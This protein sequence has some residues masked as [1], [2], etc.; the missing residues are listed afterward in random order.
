MALTVTLELFCQEKNKS[1]WIL[2]Q[3]EPKQQKWVIILTQC[4]Y[5]F[6]GLNQFS[7]LVGNRPAFI[8]FNF[9]WYRKDNT[10][11]RKDNTKRDAGCNPVKNLINNG[12]YIH[13][14]LVPRQ[15]CHCRPVRL[16]QIGRRTWRWRR[17]NWRSNWATRLKRT[18]RR[19]DGN[20]LKQVRGFLATLQ[21]LLFFTYNVI[22]TTKQQFRSKFSVTL[23]FVTIVFRV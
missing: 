22:M 1:V 16:W 5:S 10:Y 18:S 7:I 14:C 23:L 17:S 20:P 9:C 8:Y 6:G 2:W 11:N 3:N 4:Y 19:L 15:L 12:R 13:V 21:L